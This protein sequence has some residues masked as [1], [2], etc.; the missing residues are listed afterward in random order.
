MQWR[1][2]IRKKFPFPFFDRHGKNIETLFSANKRTDAE[3]IIT[4]VFCFLHVT[5]TELQQALQVQRMAEQAA[6]DRLKELAYIRQEIRNPL[7]GTIFTRK[8]MES[9]DLT[10]EQKQIVQTSALCQRQLVKVLDDADLES[11]EDGYLELDTV[12]FTLGTVLDAV[13]SQGMILCREKGLQLIRDS[14]EAITTMCLYGDQLR[15]QQILSNFLINALRFTASEGWVGIKV[16][17]T[18]R[19]LGSGVN[20]MHIEF[21]ITHPGQGIPEELIKEMFVH[22]QD[23]SREGLGLHMC[24]KLVNIMN[25]DVQYLREAGMS[26]F[27]INVEFPSAQTDK[28]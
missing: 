13:V 1:G 3:G 28:Q 16:V 10:E 6:M 21:R 15:L 8:L 5:S 9:S 14:P 4:G 20:V 7:Y 11:I 25:G 26:S 2:K 17:P 22:N 24:Q 18:K 12:E 27:I 19:H 23:M